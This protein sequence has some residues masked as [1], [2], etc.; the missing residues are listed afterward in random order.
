[1]PIKNKYRTYKNKSKFKVLLIKSNRCSKINKNNK[2]SKKYNFQW[3]YN[4]DM[5]L[6]CEFSLFII[7]HLSKF[8]NSLCSTLEVSMN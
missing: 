7:N 3:Y 4:F 5:Y 1:M 6:L 8:N 2:K